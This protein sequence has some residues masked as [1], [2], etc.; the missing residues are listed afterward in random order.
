[1][2]LNIRK[3]EDKRVCKK[4]SVCEHNILWRYDKDA[5]TSEIKTKFVIEMEFTNWKKKEWN[6]HESNS[7]KGINKFKAFRFSWRTLN[8]R[9]TAYSDIQCKRPLNILDKEK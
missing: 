1:M 6:D 7:E 4:F 5:L 2:Y 3:E 8:Y 9:V